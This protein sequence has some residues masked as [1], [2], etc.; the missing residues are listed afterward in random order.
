M[1]RATLE[2][3]PPRDRLNIIF[4]ILLLHGIGMYINLS[5]FEC[6]ICCCC[7]CWSI[8]S[9]SFLCIG[10]QLGTLMP[11]NMFI[12]AK[13]V[14]VCWL[15]YKSSFAIY[16]SS[17]LIVDYVIL[18]C[19][20]STLIINSVQIIRVLRRCMVANSKDLKQWPLKFQMSSWIGWTFSSIW[21]ESRF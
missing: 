2:I 21:G 4:F 3:N 16:F 17:F 19:V 1:E 8:F 6:I 12:N 10:G 11:W 15:V 7:F 14:S 18:M 9:A 5:H 20:C 13:S